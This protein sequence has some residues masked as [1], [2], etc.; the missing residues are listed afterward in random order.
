MKILAADLWPIAGADETFLA[1]AD[2]ERVASQMR[3][4]QIVEN[5]LLYEQVVVP[6]DNLLSVRILADTFGVE[7]LALLIDEGVIR[8]VRFR[9]MLAY[10]G[11]GHGVSSITSV[12]PGTTGQPLA[13]M[14]LPTGVAVY[15]ILRGI[16]GLTDRRAK[17]MAVKFAS[18]TKEIELGQAFCA[19]IRDSTRAVALSPLL[20]ESLKILSPDLDNLPGK[21]ANQIIIP[22]K[23]RQPLEPNNDIGRLLRIARTQQEIIA[24]RH[25]HCEDLSTLSPIG[26]ILSTEEG[27]ALR[28]LYEITEA[29]DVGTAVMRGSAS[30]GQVIDLRNSRH[31]QEFANWFHDTCS[32]DAARVGRE[33]VKLLRQPSALDSP[34][35]KTVRL[36][37]PAAIGVISPITGVDAARQICFS[38]PS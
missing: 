21:N 27:I 38:R 28:H 29:P 4:Q 36:L 9:G 20:D 33:Y 1:A 32:S 13:P 11:E 35:F 19:E 6:T 17:Q 23:F 5:I 26:K 22:G 25:M 37:I 15:E 2:A 14:W 31:W 16:P 30:L 12:S 18:A 24:Q 3:L 34:F 7:G 8:F 10:V